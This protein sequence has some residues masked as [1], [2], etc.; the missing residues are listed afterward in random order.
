MQHRAQGGR[1]RRPCI[2]VFQKTDT[3]VARM[4]RCGFGRSGRW[5]LQGV[6]LFHE[7]PGLASG[8]V[9]RGGACLCVP[10][11]VVVRFRAFTRQN[12]PAVARCTREIEPAVWPAEAL[13]CRPCSDLQDGR[14][15]ANRPDVAKV[16]GGWLQDTPH[17]PHP[18]PTCLWAIAMIFHLVASKLAS[19]HTPYFSSTPC[20]ASH[21]W[22]SLPPWRQQ[23]SQGRRRR[24]R[25]TMRG[26]CEKEERAARGGS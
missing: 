18:L 9:R 26:G 20:I 13:C 7:S 8:S 2:R 19:G 23:W 25:C 17:F 4:T 11:W 3:P 1:S 12:S 6:D 10:G 14:H 21:A 16:G 15:R 22:R 24:R 5:E